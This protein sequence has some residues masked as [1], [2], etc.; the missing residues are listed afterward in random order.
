MPRSGGADAALDF[1]GDCGRIRSLRLH[2][3]VAFDKACDKEHLRADA[4]R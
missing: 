3:H 1:F 2:P 4:R